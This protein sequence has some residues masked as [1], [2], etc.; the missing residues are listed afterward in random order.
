MK[1]A[2][3]LLCCISLFASCDENDPEDSGVPVMTVE[4]DRNAF[5][6][7]QVRWIYISDA[8]GD[9]LDAEVVRAGKFT[10][11]AEYLPEQVDVTIYSILN[12]DNTK[13]HMLE[14]F[15]RVPV[16]K[17]LKVKKLQNPNTIPP[18]VIGS[19]SF[20][21]DNYQFDGSSGNLTISNGAFPFNFSPFL[22]SYENLTMRGFYSL[23]A[24]KTNLL[25]VTPRNGLRAYYWAK[26]VKAGDALVLD[27]QNFTDC[28]YTIGLP[29]DMYGQALGILNDSLYFIGSTETLPALGQNALSYVD[30][31]DYYSTSL[32]R[33]VNGRYCN[34]TKIGDKVQ[35]IEFPNFQGY[36]TNTS[37]ENFSYTETESYTYRTSMWTY[38][39]KTIQWLVYGDE[40]PL[41]VKFLPKQLKESFPNLILGGFTFSGQTLYKHVDDFT[42]SDLVDARLGVTESSPF[43]EYYL[44]NSF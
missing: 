30:G 5:P 27:H 32:S 9:V 37:F 26:N 21:I 16:S 1:R 35:S 10:L 11:N 19:V 4:V 6:R 39:G 15:K 22:V 17:I 38:P 28:E 29:Y 24:G 7:D 14:T 18:Q 41:Q 40:N 12:I 3:L 2:T 31:F 23:A 25:F 8:N 33:Y 13:T 36:L 42:Y 20:E 43:H 34:Y 44:V